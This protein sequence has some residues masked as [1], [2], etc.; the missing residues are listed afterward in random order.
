MKTVW[1]IR[2]FLNTDT[3]QLA[4]LWREHHATLCPS[5]S[6][7][8]SVWDQCILSKPFFDQ[9]GLAIAVNANGESVGFVHFGFASNPA[10]TR[11]S[12]VNGVIHKICVTP[13]S[14]QDSIAHEL[15]KHALQS[16]KSQGATG[17]TAL[18][19]MERHAFYLG[20]VEGDNLMG[21]VS[22]DTRTQLWLSQIGLAPIRPTEC[23]ELDLIHFR[24]P[25]DR[26]QIGIRRT[27][28]VGRLLDEDSH[29]WWLSSV[30]GHCEQVRFNLVLRSPPRVETE[31]MYWFP[32]PTITGVDSSIVRL[33]LTTV[34]QAE[35]ARERFVY[36]MAE[37]LR[38]LQ[39]DRKQA[40]RTYASADQQPTVTLLQRLGFRS[41]ESGLV[42]FID[43]A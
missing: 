33:W 3:P 20:V 17:C 40:V 30:L 10:G 1:T 14:D 34:P 32:D 37:S 31:L 29:Q 12:D 15:L 2:S 5:A 38:Q 43:L 39:L 42:Y 24:P 23:W 19:T 18:G 6:C 13:C 16:L 4:R 22:R 36:L 41:I 9:T 27:C 28:T 26:T 11:A 21:V 7:P 25:M 35:E 8:V